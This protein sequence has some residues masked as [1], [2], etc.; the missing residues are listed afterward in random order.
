MVWYG[1]IVL[2][3]AM[4]VWFSQTL[5]HVSHLNSVQTTPLLSLLNPSLAQGFECS[6]HFRYL[7]RCQIVWYHT[8]I[9][10]KYGMVWLLSLPSRL[11]PVSASRPNCIRLAPH[12]SYPCA[13]LQAER[14]HVHRGHHRHHSRMALQAQTS[15]L[16]E[17]F[18]RSAS[19]GRPLPD[20][21]AG[22][23]RQ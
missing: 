22:G 2:Y 20:L 1:T 13:T 8:P 4:M 15:R 5:Y 6:L 12:G 3:L 11:S 21:S 10:G 14:A 7:V 16:H 23:A 19:P 17:P 9:F 18:Q